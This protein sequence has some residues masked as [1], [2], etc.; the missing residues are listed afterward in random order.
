MLIIDKLFGKPLARPVKLWISQD[1]FDTL[2]LDHSK[3]VE[4]HR[5][6]ESALQQFLNLASLPF[7]ESWVAGM[8]DL[9]PGKSVCIGTVFATRG[10]LVPNTTGVDIGC[11]MAAI[12]TD[13]VYDGNVALL[14]EFVAGMK[15]NVPLGFNHREVPLEDGIYE[16]ADE[17]PISQRELEKAKH[18][19]GT[20]G[21]G[22]HF[23]YFDTDEEGFLYVVVHTGSRNLGLKICSEYDEI[24]KLQNKKWCSVG[25]EGWELAYL[26]ID[27]KEG[28]AYFK[29]LKFAQK[30]AKQNRH[31]ILEFASRMFEANGIHETERIECI[32]NYISVENIMGKNLF[33]TR[34]GAVNA[35][36]GKLVI[37]GGNQMTGSV[38]AVGK[39]NVQA[40]NSCSHGAGRAMSRT[41][42]KNTLS[43]EEMKEQ[44][45]GIVTSEEISEKMLDEAPNAYKNLQSVLD[46]EN[47][48]VTV[49]NRLKTVAVIKDIEEAKPW[50]KKKPKV[51]E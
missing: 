27:S 25:E 31:H 49:R 15:A 44:M 33:V 28:G 11:G 14:K 16:E 46:N 24:A 29:E 13:Y 47:D 4:T 51:E 23:L 9:H 21:G 18:A 39:G 42:A 3:L 43:V 34:K 5:E 50:Q 10:Q 41:E 2:V 7:I 17:C 20:L 26:P 19:L 12:K 48:L 6:N 40:F 37:I 36:E 38:I 35:Q 45:K 8:P 22:N 32:H 30:Y 1:E